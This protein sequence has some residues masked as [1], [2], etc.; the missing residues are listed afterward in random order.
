MSINAVGYYPVC[1]SQAQKAP[2][3]QNVSFAGAEKSNPEKGKSFGKGFASLWMTGLGQMFD[4]RVKTG[5][6]QLGTEMGLGAVSGLAS[7]LAVKAM[8][9]GSRVGLIA[10][11]GLGVV[12]GIGA[13]ANKIH[14]IVDA[15][16]GG[17]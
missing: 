15:Y 2:A 3:K 11:I 9:S 4:G 8:S 6:K 12:A 13:I 1:C 5:F 16:K 10:S 7:V 14:S 17:K